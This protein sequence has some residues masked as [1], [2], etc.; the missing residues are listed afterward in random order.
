MCIRDRTS[1]PSVI[2][3]SR[4]DHGDVVLTICTLNPKVPERA[5]VKLNMPALGA[6]W[7][8]QLR[9]QDLVSDAVWTWGRDVYVELDP[10]KAVAHVV[11]VRSL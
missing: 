1:S 3:Y 11:S 8:A 9:A 2:A 10:F 4:K 5:T 6:D 7:D